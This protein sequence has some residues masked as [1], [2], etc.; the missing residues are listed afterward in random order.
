[1]QVPSSAVYKTGL[2]A[3]VWVKTGTTQNGTGIFQLRKVITGSSSNGMTT[4]KSGLSSDEEIAVQAGLMT[5]SETFLNE[6]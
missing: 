6:K 1:M 2:N 3:Y 5:D 4:I